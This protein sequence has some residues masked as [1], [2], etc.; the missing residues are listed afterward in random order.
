MEYH[1]FV[2]SLYVCVCVCVCVEWQCKLELLFP[3]K[4]EKKEKK[5]LIVKIY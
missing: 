5:N 1:V 4:K 2:S 3:E